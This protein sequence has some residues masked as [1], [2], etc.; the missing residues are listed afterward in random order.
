MSDCVFLMSSER[1]GS[2]LIRV[3]LNSHPA[4]AAPPPPHLIDVFLPVLPLYGDVRQES[5]FER[6]ARD[7]ARVLG[8]QMASWQ[9]APAAES[10]IAKARSRSFAALVL[11]AYALEAEARESRRTLVKDNGVIANPFFVL[12][13]FPDSKVVYLVRDARDVALSFK[14]SSVH[15]ETLSE[16]AR[17]W[18]E[19]QRAALRAIAGSSR[20]DSFFFLHYEDLVSNPEQTLR[21][22]CAFLDE[23]YASSMLDFHSTT[24]AKSSAANLQAWKNLT[25]P[26][27]KS[28][29]AKYRTQLSKRKIKAVERYAAQE[30]RLLGYPLTSSPQPRLLSRDRFGQWIGLGRKVL[31]VALDGRSGFRELQIRRRRFREVHSV[32]SDLAPA[33]EPWAMA[34]VFKAGDGD[35]TDG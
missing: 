19:Q 15:V 24:E 35:R 5:N 1:S 2:N 8:N 13:A 17:L 22:L 33:P 4:I 11:A 29:F 12:T 20:H 14:K 10:L 18:A 21:G 23:E 16:A 25:E 27:M 31:Q 9:L 3:M 7:I 6:L 30:L 34:R 26:V 28:N 32:T